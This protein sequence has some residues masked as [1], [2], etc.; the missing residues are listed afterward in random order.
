MRVLPTALPTDEQ[1]GPHDRPGVRRIRFR[2]SRA[3]SDGG[4]WVYLVGEGSEMMAPAELDELTADPSRSSRFRRHE[5]LITQTTIH[6]APRF[7]PTPRPWRIE[8]APRTVD[9]ARVCGGKLF[10]CLSMTAPLD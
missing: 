2:L 10:P 9:E 8:D 7:H 3:E 1:L 4:K 6:D 5:G